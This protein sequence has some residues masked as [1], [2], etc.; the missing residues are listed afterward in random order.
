M[1]RYETPDDAEADIVTRV[2]NKETVIGFGHPSTRRRP[3]QQDHQGSR[4]ALSQEAAT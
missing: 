4:A 3:A 2:R 1:N